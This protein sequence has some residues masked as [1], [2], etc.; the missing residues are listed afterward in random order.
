MDTRLGLDEI[1][2]HIE[3]KTK[4][5]NGESIHSAVTV[6]TRV[7]KN[8]L[9]IYWVQIA[10]IFIVII[11]SLF[12]LSMKWGNT[13]IWLAVFAWAVGFLIPGPKLKTIISIMDQPKQSNLN[14]HDI[15]EV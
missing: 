10:I 6:S 5:N 13:E 12:N 14:I 15:P 11:T 4:N 1:G 3:N 7:E 9:I 2:S 8:D